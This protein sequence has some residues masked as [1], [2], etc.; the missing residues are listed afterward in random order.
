MLFLIGYYT[1]RPAADARVA[2]QHR[3]AV[4]LAVFLEL[5][6]VH[7]A[8]DDFTHVVLFRGIAGKDSINVVRGIQRLARSDVAEGGGARSTNL[9][10]QR[11]NP[12]DPRNVIQR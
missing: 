12:H 2:A 4:T 10:D 6:G 3:L 7:D 9:V 1:D 8:R 5:A 11:A